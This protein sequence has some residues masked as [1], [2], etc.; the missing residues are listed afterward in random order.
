MPR[1]LAIDPDA[2][3]LFVASAT[4]S[5]NSIKIEQTAFI[6]DSGFGLSPGNAAAL[7][8]ALR[9]LLKQA[10]IAPAPILMVLGRERTIL[11]EVRF[12]ITPPA[13]EP[14]IVKFQA[15]KELSEAPEEMIF[16]YT[17]MPVAPGQTDRSALVV[18]IKR[19][20][21]TA[22]RTFAETAGL[23]LAGVAPRSFAAAMATGRAI[24]SG[25]APAPESANGP[26]AI[27][28]LT[29]RAGEFTVVQAGQVRFARS[30][31]AMA[32]TNEQS[33]LVELRRN[34][35]V[36]SQAVNSF[37]DTLY[38]AEGDATG[39]SWFGRLRAGL[40]VT[41][42]AFDPLANIPA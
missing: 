13:D 9:D 20:L 30:L 6:P 32:M 19:E 29:D 7:G 12:P 5:R 22:T 31:P 39:R 28:T 1:F 21:M 3:G 18:F 4:V 15:I 38:L 17:P 26:A 11:K 36:A 37:I 34:L 35:T 8:V 14:A 10:K 27:L 24:A 42:H 23:K 2:S 41:V 25:A 33:L 16:D 40:P